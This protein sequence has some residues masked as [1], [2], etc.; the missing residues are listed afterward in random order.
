MDYERRKEYSI[1]VVAKDNI[2][3][4]SNQKTTQAGP[5]TIFVLDVNDNAPNLDSMP[6]D[7]VPVYENAKILFIVTTIQA[8]DPDNGD[9]G[10]VDYKLTSDTNATGLFMIE[11]VYNP[12]RRQNDGVI[13]L[14]QV[15]LA[16]VGI[17]YITVRASDRGTPQMVSERRL[18]IQ[19]VDVN[20]HQPVFV[21]PEGPQSSISIEEV[22]F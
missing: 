7:P 11:S 1:Y 18:Y 12:N 5:I 13:K 17:V 14:Q 10:T 20:L 15:L 3:D 16:Q 21:Y 2:G 4:P 6:D 22:L 19:I 8:T 9:N